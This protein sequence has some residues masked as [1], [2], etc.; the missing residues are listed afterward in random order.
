MKGDK[1]KGAKAVKADLQVARVEEPR[2]LR[3]CGFK[4]W[5]I[6]LHTPIERDVPGAVRA[7]RLAR[8]RAI[9]RPLTSHPR[10]YSRGPWHRR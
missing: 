5:K 3:S 7:L 2:V 1:G 9:S 10:R 4:G 8:R 6:V